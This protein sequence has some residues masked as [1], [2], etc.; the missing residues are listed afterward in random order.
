MAGSSHSLKSTGRLPIKFGLYLG[1]TVLLA[2]LLALIFMRNHLADSSS[3]RLPILGQVPEFRFVTQSNIPFG[4]AGLLGKTSVICFFFTRCHSICPVMSTKMAE[5]YKEYAAFP[6]IQFVSIDV[7]PDYDSLPV[8]QKYAA[9]FGVTDDRWLFLRGPIDE[10]ADLSENGFM[11]S[12]DNL[13]ADHSSRFVL[14]DRQARIRGYYDPFSDS[15]LIEL[16]AAI[17]SLSSR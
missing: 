3:D 13:P 5:L 2:L 17:R 10:V 6:D 1:A 12:A 11:L 7:D 14:V 4:S 15:S 16:R 8:L 9:A